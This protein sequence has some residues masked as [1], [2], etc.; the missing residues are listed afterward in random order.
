MTCSVVSRRR[1]Y[2]ATGECQSEQVKRRVFGTELTEADVI[3]AE[4][5]RPREALVRIRVDTRNYLA[6]DYAEREHVH[7]NGSE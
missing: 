1:T 2:Q 6:G 3:E 4:D 5:L 7:L